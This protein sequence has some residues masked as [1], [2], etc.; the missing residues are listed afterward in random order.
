MEWLRKLDLKPAQLLKLVGLTIV[1]IIVLA[2]GIRLIG[3]AVDSVRRQR[4]QESMYNLAE[5]AGVAADNYL[6]GSMVSRDEN[7]SLSIRN[8][9]GVPEMNIMPPYYGGTAGSDAEAY[10][11]KDYFASIETRKL[12]DTCS[13]ISDLKNRDDVIFESSSQHE[14]ACSF[15]FKVAGESVSEILEFIKGFEPEE[16]NEN[17]QTIKNQVQD[18]TSQVQI[19]E[20]KLAAIDETLTKA[21]TAYDEVTVLA[22]RSQDAGSLAKIIDSKVNIIERLTQERINISAQLEQISRQKSEQLDR[23]DYSYFNVS[24]RENKYFDGDSLKESW[25]SA[26]KQFV[27]DVN[28]IAQDISVNL[29]V[30]LLLVVQYLLYFFIL[31]VIAKFVWQIVKRVWRS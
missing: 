18:F 22:T 14:R 3:S 1:V 23:L 5:T 12:S 28:K 10:E 27:Y 30:W 29:V 31:L 2:V 13:E 16:L 24:V 17:S 7:I 21:L 15:T 11:V 19:L 8:M 20:N 25:Q 6:K 9:A 4:A 26:A